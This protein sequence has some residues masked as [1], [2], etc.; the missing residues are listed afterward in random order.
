MRKRMAAA[1][2]GICLTAALWGCQ[3]GDRQDASGNG[4]ATEAE[5][6]S[7]SS[8][9][10]A[11]QEVQPRETAAAP[12]A[13]DGNGPGVGDGSGSVVYF[14]SDISPEGLMAVY[15]ALGWEPSGKVA[16][17]LSTGEPPASNYLDPALIKDLVQSV[18]ASIVECNTAYG[19]S[20]TETAMHR[21]VAEDHGFTAIA[22][23]DIL[24]ED[25]SMALPVEG[26]THLESN[27]VGAILPTMI[28]TLSCPI[29]RDMRW[30]G[31]AAR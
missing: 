31:S 19:G 25:G 7:E 16:V 24:D 29:S 9:T 27:L 15:E 5:N 12:V 2:C 1:L 4:T 23:V 8:E 28:P 11:A 22:D 17:K 30:P 13:A 21:Q 3:S 6:S 10:T 20:R 26:G 14:T 18:D